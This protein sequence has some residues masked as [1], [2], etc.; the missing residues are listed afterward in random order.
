MKA[1]MFIITGMIA[2]LSAQAQ[3]QKLCTGGDCL[4][5]GYE[6]YDQFGSLSEI[7]TCNSG[8]CATQGWTILRAT[9]V[10]TSVVC[11]DNSCFGKGFQEINPSNNNEMIR[12]RT[13]A[14]AT[15]GGA[16]DCFAN[17][18]EDEHFGVNARVEQ[19][20]CTDG[21]SCKNGFIIET[22]VDQT[23]L[24]EEEITD[25]KAE[26]QAKKIELKEYLK[27]NHKMN[28]TL[29]REIISLKKQILQLKK[30]LR[31]GD[32]VQVVD[33][34]EAVCLSPGGCFKDGYQLF[35][36]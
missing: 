18:W 29:L 30:E 11:S 17:G 33:S 28:F 24:L 36:Y 32:G 12:T 7:A 2:S 9:G 19:I 20:S 5:S 15:S 13:C 1:L 22:I 10:N 35:E 27:T 34:Q 16:G 23:A 14:A 25:L 8:D 21:I 6:Y 3:E 31:N 4:T 26:A